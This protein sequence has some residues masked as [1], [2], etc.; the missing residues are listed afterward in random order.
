MGLIRALKR[1][2]PLASRSDFAAIDLETIDRVAAA[3]F[4]AKDGEIQE[5][6]AYN[7]ENIDFV[8]EEERAFPGNPDFLESGYYKKMLKRYLFAGKWFCEGKAVLDSCSGLGW[9][10]QLISLFAESVVAFDAEPRAVQF[11]RETWKA[12]NVDWCEGDAL[13]PRAEWRARFDVALGM[14]TIEHFSKEDGRA[15]VASVAQ[16][17]APGGYFLGTSSFP[18]TAQKAAQ[19]CAKNPYHLHVFTQAE[20]N[21]ILGEFFVDHAIVDRWMFMARKAQTPR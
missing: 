8:G 2:N 14:E 6:L 17:L 7:S 3:E 19:L 15:Y 1:L 13:D 16:T 11:C 20:M 18:K 4:E 12:R 21:E 9:G 5:I 10:T